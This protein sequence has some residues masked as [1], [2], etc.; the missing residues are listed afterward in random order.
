MVTNRR[1]GLAVGSALACAVVTASCSGTGTP[2]TGSPDSQSS[3]VTASSSSVVTLDFV[4]GGGVFSDIEMFFDY[5]RY[6]WH[7][8][9]LSVA[10][11]NLG[12]EPI[13]ISSIALR[14]D[15]FESLPAEPKRTVIAPGQRVDVQVDFG[16]L[17]TCS[18]SEEVTG[19]VAVTLA[20]GDGPP[21]DHLIVLDPRQLD[22][23]R[24]RE[25]MQQ[26]VGAVASI[27]FSAQRSIDGMVMETSIE[28]V[29]NA[30]TPVIEIT[31]LSS[32]V[33]LALVPV[34][35]DEPLLR[36]GP[37]VNRASVP[38]RLEVSRCDPH[39]VSQSSRTFDLAAYVS[40]DG[41]ESHRHLLEIDREMQSDLQSMIDACT[42]FTTG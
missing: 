1:W 6:L 37:D 29:R 27:A 19:A 7:I 25:C 5:P 18:P 2:T 22:E 24:D 30:G 38:I 40:I 16:P 12:D 42:A 20:R 26:R 4:T 11:T 31:S 23:I 8:R 34:V 32:S 21:V 36:V 28:V 15:H 33:I 17:T 13:T 10:T 9:R 35:D 3:E 41:G 14:A 39:V